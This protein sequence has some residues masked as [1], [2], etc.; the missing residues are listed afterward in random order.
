MMHIKRPFIMLYILIIIW[1]H[2]HR[3]E[4]LFKSLDE[5]QSDK[6]TKSNINKIDFHTNSSYNSV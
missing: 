3:L 5:K 6:K 2:F 1:K 4:H